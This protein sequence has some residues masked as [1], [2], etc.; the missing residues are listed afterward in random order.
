MLPR[1]RNAPVGLSG[2]GM[3]LAAAV[4]G[5]SLLGYWIDRRFE[6]EPWGILICAFIGIVGG[7]YNFVLA[8]RQAME[9]TAEGGGMDSPGDS[10]AA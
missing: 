7:L 10:D 4:V 2:L 1:R 9:R 5:F 6:T 3:E 8:A